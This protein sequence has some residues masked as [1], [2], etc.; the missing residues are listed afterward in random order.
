MVKQKKHTLLT[1]LS[2]ILIIVCIVGITILSLF[3]N[4]T[5]K[6]KP[7]DDVPPE[8]DPQGPNGI[9]KNIVFSNFLQNRE[10]LDSVGYHSYDYVIKNIGT[11]KVGTDIRVTRQNTTDTDQNLSFYFGNLLNSINDFTNVKVAYYQ[12]WNESE[13]LYKDLDENG[14]CVFTY[15]ANKQSSV[16]IEYFLLNDIKIYPICIMYDYGYDDGAN[17]LKGLSA[18]YYFDGKY[19]HGFA[20]Y[21]MLDLLRETYDI[22]QSK[23]DDVGEFSTLTYYD[24][25]KA[26][27]NTILEYT[28]DTYAS[29]FDF[30]VYTKLQK[31]MFMYAS[32]NISNMRVAD[33]Q[34]I[35][36]VYLGN[37]FS[38]Y[39][40]TKCSVASYNYVTKNYED[41]YTLDE[42]GFVEISMDTMLQSEIDGEV[43]YNININFPMVN[44]KP[45]LFDKLAVFENSSTNQYNVVKL[46]YM[47]D[48]KMCYGLLSLNSEEY[49]RFCT[50]KNITKELTY[51]T[52]YVG[53][54]K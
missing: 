37:L 27:N 16:E 54:V 12:D 2:V 17:V 36:K 53:N 48:G 35:I 1:V 3:L 26:E 25:H 4:G 20:D 23:Y 15:P 30:S 50:E 22:R 18:Q 32:V 13:L 33:G 28:E 7:N 21:T 10:Y 52:I 45:Y 34:E 14:T 49:T 19:Y 39:D 46:R 9:V 11:T 31:S 42:N 29:D 24:Y 40:Y 44:N 47:I 41:R 6:I 38:E 51:G 5:I 8:Y 43:R